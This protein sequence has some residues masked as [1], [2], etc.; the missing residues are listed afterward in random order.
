MALGLAAPALAYTPNTPPDETQSPYEIEIYLVEHSGLD[1]LGNALQL[2]A[3]DRGYAK[4]E[5][6]AAIGKLVIPKG[7]DVFGDGY[8]QLRFRPENVSLN[9]SEN[10]FMTVP[11]AGT[12]VNAVLTNNLSTT[13]NT[14]PVL[15]NEWWYTLSTNLLVHT[16][17][18][19]APLGL[20]SIPVNANA[21]VTMRWLV[22][23]KVGGEDAKLTFQLR[24][25]PAWAAAGA[26]YLSAMNPFGA[27]PSGSIVLSEDFLVYHLKS[28][29]AVI[30]TNPATWLIHENAVGLNHSGAAGDAPG[31]LRFVIETSGSNGKTVRLYMYPNGAVSEYYRIL[32]EPSGQHLVFEIAGFPSAGHSAYD[33]IKYGT[34]GYDSLLAFYTEWFEGKLGFSA[35]NEGNLL[36]VS[37]WETIAAAA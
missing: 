3:T 19:P 18:A 32:V 34:A 25:N 1:L 14:T 17:S 13:Q 15:W 4:N 16:I 31:P 2:P 29:G 37:D 23:G 8:T 24:R 28:S 6:I 21:D 7:E 27:V 9:V 35:Y 20:G 12:T 11:A 30:P 33:Q 36:R 10:A 22:F 5:I 26:G